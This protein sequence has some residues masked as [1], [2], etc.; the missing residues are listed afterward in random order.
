[1]KTKLTLIALLMLSSLWTPR[2]MADTDVKININLP[3]VQIKDEP[4]MAVI[5]GTYIYFIYGY[6]HDFFFHGGYW[7][8]FNNNRWYRAHHYNG[9]WKYRKD[10]YVPA[11]FF[12]L[13]PEWRKMVTAHSGIKHQDMKKNWKQWEKEKRWDK[14]QDQKGIKKEI[15]EEKQDKKDDKDKPA[16]DN[17]K[18]GKGRK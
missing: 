17:K 4:V 15:K 13:S 1:M 16:K 18:S 9:P 7:W 10:K 11:P 3:L 14:K 6:E 2:L 5:P 8:R 12:K